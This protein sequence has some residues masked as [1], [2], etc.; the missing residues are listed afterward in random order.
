[1]PSPKKDSVSSVPID[2]ASIAD[3]IIS[4]GLG[5]SRNSRNKHYGR[6]PEGSAIPR[7]PSAPEQ[8]TIAV[9]RSRPAWRRTIQRDEQ[10][11]RSTADHEHNGH[12][13]THPM[14]A[15]TASSTTGMKDSDRK[16]RFLVLQDSEVS[17]GLKP[18]FCA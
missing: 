15:E 5:V 8:A 1:M 16:T 11:C 7:A 9:M 13:Q 4:K 14:S 3:A 2:I 18:C 12:G 6:K 10:R 17:G